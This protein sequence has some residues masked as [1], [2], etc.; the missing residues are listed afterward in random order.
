MKKNRTRFHRI[1]YKVFR[2]VVWIWLRTKMRFDFSTQPT[3]PDQFLLISNH[4]TNFD[5][6][7]LGLATRRLIYYVATEHI[8]SLG[9]LTK[10]IVWLVDPIPR[11][12]AGQAAGTVLEIKRRLKSGASVGLFAEGNCSWD[13]LTASFAPA[14]GKMVRAS[15]ASL[16]T[17]RLRGGYFAYPRWAYSARR[18]PVWLEIT[19]IV[20]PEELKKMK[21]D[22]IN[23]LIADGI[24]EDAYETRKESGALYPGRRLAEGLENALLFCPR[25]HGFDTLRSKGSGFSCTCGLKGCYDENGFLTAEGTDFTTIREWN[26]WQ[27]SYLDSLPPAALPVPED[28]DMQLLEI[29]GHE[30]SLAASGRLR[31]DAGSL[32]L[33]EFSV[34]VSDIVSL[35][36]RLRGTVSFLTRDG[37]YFEIKKQK[38]KARYNGRK[39]QLLYRRL[40]KETDGA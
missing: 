11:P 32:S 39:Y 33:G 13:G 16:V 19:H 15:G 34:P 21:P 28:E 40:Q 23:A 6:F 1:V 3:L 25:C 7:L 24:R 26:A 17:C 30:R 8:F 38:K 27:L 2:P 4:V 20:S 12:K 35:D 36:V 37:G 9:W 5:P 10:L 18:G 22:Q 14:T 29:S 31:M